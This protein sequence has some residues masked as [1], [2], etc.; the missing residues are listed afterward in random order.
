MT[1]SRVLPGRVCPVELFHHRQPSDIAAGF[2]VAPGIFYRVICLVL[3]LMINSSI[4]L[5]SV[6]VV[7]R[8]C[9]SVMFIAAQNISPLSC[10]SS[11]Y[12]QVGLRSFFFI[13]SVF[14]VLGKFFA[15]IFENTAGPK[16]PSNIVIRRH[17]NGQRRENPERS[18]TKNFVCPSAT[19]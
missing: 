16:R 6:A 18:G 17:N 7:I 3:S 1:N 2:H 8:A 9:R 15:H 13:F 11:E 19:I 5:C 4:L 14:V 12:C 10:T